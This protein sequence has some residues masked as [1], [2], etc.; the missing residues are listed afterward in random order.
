LS[1]N[2]PKIE[3]GPAVPLSALDLPPS[4]RIKPHQAAYDPADGDCLIGGLFMIAD[5]PP[6]PADSEDLDL[7]FELANRSREWYVHSAQIV[8][9]QRATLVAVVRRKGAPM[10]ALD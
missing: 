10:Y 5:D 9:D 2:L 4:V 6:P 3:W 7:W 1:S 8:V